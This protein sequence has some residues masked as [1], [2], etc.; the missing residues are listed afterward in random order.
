MSTKYIFVTGGVTS[1]LGK[2][3]ICASLGRLLVARGLNVTVQK[4]DPYINVDPGTM[5][6][7]EHGEV[8]VTED[9]AETDL[10]LGH[11][12]RFLDI[13]TSQENN[14][15]TG[16]V[17]NDVI[18]KERQGAYLGK[19]VQVIPHITDEIKS[20]IV[21]LGESGDYD[22]VITEI[23]G[24][25]GD[26]ESLP[27]IEAV[28]QLRY[29][30]GRSNTL[31]I[32]L[33]LVPYLSA[34]RELKTKPTQHSVKTLSESGLQPDIIV[35]RS[36]YELDDTIRNKIAQFCNVEYDDVIASLDAE[37]IYQVPF[38]MQDEGLDKRVIEKL[39][40]EAGD[41]DLERWKGFVEA[42]RNPSTEITIALVGKYVEHHDA[43]K[44]I[45]EALIHGGAV[46]DCEVNIRWLQSD[47]LT[48]EN[49]VENLED[50]SGVLVAPGFGGRG[51]DG[52][53][54]AANY[55]REN[56]IPYFGI[57]LG[58]QCAVIEFARNVC[59]WETANST[60]FD[61]DSE[62]PIIDLMP[63]QK[64]IEEKGGTMRL[65]LYDCKIKKDTKTYEA[66]GEE[67]V[68]ER[69]RHRYEVNNNL[70]Y[71]LVE[72]GMKL[73]GFNPERDL[74]EIIELPDHPWF[75]GVQFHPE[76][77]STVNNPQPLFVDFVKASLKHAK[78]ND[79]AEP[80]KREKVVIN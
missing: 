5:N 25:V 17:Y 59:G 27:Y 48:K 63:D 33:T 77:C 10:D 74:V 58:M 69:H 12:E 37:S 13:K 15:T 9:G 67:L 43:Y 61:E 79:L 62:Y 70:R 66:Y 71:K 49:I 30:V 40:L 18:S 68:Q 78:D 26:I 64:N 57:C 44:S 24:T 72:D 80:I 28:R 20:H 52:K 45:V 14:V 41:A 19:T 22:V 4:L 21:D 3:I 36:E 47:D 35:A 46:N 53:L 32:H 51:I 6:P 54:A 50:V 16:R 8:Y 34:A 7:Y 38:M 75:V 31:S 23:G 56:G 2:G 11:Y 65:G 55:A 39:K 60:E 29:D 1:S 76:Y 73:V 42:I